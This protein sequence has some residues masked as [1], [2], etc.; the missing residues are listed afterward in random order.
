MLLRLNQLTIPYLSASPTGIWG[1]DLTFQPGERIHLRARSG[2]GK[3]TLMQTLYGLQKK[4]EGSIFFDDQSLQSLDT[5]SMCT[6][7]QEKISIIFQDLRLFPELSARDNLEVKRTLTNYYPAE[8]MD[9]FA[10]RL[11]VTSLLNRR[12]D[13]LSYGERQRIAIIRALLQ[14]FQLLLLDEP[15]SHLDEENIQLATA[16]I[17]EEVAHRKATLFLADL[18][19]D[20]R[21][22]YTQKICL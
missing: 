22:S 5:N 21:F 13:T 20:D 18:E 2:Q 16:L 11:G 1:R 10:Q 4:Y 7:R 12:T 17:A 9:D 15:F 3:T 8:R 6:L 14:P 19:D